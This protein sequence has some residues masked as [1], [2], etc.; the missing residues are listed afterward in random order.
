VQKCSS[1]AGSSGSFIQATHPANV[2]AVFGA[3]GF[4]PESWSE[5]SFAAEEALWTRGGLSKFCTIN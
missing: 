4:A 5:T 2:S 1:F 3:V